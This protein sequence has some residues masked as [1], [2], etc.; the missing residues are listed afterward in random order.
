MIGPL[1]YLSLKTLYV[2]LSP[3]EITRE[4]CK[5]M[6]PISQGIDSHKVLVV[7]N[8]GKLNDTIEVSALWSMYCLHQSQKKGG[9]GRKSCS[10][11]EGGTHSF[12]SYKLSVERLY[13]SETNGENRLRKWMRI[14]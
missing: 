13:N 6:I 4:L 12:M 1:S 5:L 8:N 10:Y 9:G 11:A 2:L 14:G 3:S 7:E